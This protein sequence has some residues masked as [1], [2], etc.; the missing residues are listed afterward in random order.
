MALAGCGESGG[1]VCNPPGIRF[2]FPQ[3][4]LTIA[5]IS[6]TINSVPSPTIS[7]PVAS[8]GHGLHVDNDWRSCSNE[9]FAGCCAPP[10][11][12]TRLTK[13]HRSI[14]DRSHDD[15]RVEWEWAAGGEHRRAS[16]RR[17]ELV[18]GRSF[19]MCG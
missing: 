19:T 2:D 6:G 13:A 1:T 11:G 14:G 7:P 9:Y 15:D 8:H 5:A 18:R 10:I 12:E 16:A 17:V 3:P 4:E